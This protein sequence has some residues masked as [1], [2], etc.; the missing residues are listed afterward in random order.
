M[1]IDLL[2]SANFGETRRNGLSLVVCCKAVTERPLRTRKRTFGCYDAEG[3]LTTQGGHLI[4]A[5]IWTV[6]AELQRL[7]A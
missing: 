2:Q 1:V 6:G 5:Q 3:P 7:S 4:W